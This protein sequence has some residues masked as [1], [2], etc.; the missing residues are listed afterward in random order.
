MEFIITIALCE[1]KIYLL[2]MLKSAV[3]WKRGSLPKKTLL[4]YI[5]KCPNIV[6]TA[7][8]N[9]QEELPSEIKIKI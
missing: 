5:K 6:E 9:R 4:I 1:L 7:V 8:Q 2:F 3:N